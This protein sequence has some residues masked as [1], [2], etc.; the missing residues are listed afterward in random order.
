MA[1]AKITVPKEGLPKKDDNVVKLDL[2][3]KA[4]ELKE[5]EKQE[6]NAVQAQKTDDSNAV[7]EEQ[8]DSSNS[9][10]V[11]EEVRSVATSK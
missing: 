10:G 7:V 8:K 1:D 9:E 5:K 3:K 6:D 4:Q 2:T 11:V